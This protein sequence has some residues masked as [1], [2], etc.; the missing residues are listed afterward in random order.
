MFVSLF[1]QG[2]K[3]AGFS[4]AHRV[5]VVIAVFKKTTVVLACRRKVNVALVW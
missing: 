4:A 1:E 2:T 5:G 3:E